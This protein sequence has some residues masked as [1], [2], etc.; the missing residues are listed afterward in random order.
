MSD[1]I[2]N[3][4]LKAAGLDPSMNFPSTFK[5]MTVWRCMENKVHACNFGANIPCNSKEHRRNT[6]P[7]DVGLLQAVS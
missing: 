6:H 2:F 7:V 1:T 4:Y 5:Q 3:G